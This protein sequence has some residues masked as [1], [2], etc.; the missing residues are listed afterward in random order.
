MTQDQ[1]RG[2]APLLAGL[3]MFGPFAIDTMFPAFPEIAREFGANEWLMQQTLSAYLIAYALMSLFHGPVSDTY[4]RRGVIVGSVVVFLAASVGCAL[5]WSIESLLFFRVV[6]GISAGA[7]QIVGRAIIRDL[8][9]GPAAQRLMSNIS[10]M[11]TIAPAVAPIVGGW[12]LGLGHW[13][14][15]FWFLVAWSVVLL[16]ACLWRLP[17]T[18]PRERRVPL[19]VRELV[20]SYGGM[21][22]DTHFWPLAIAGTV[23]FSAMFLYISCAP[24]FVMEQLK[25]S[26]QQFAWLFVPAVSGMFLGALASSRLAGKYDARKTVGLGYIVMLCASALNVVL[27]AWVLPHPMVPWSVLPIGLHAIGISMSFP[28]IA[29]L[30]I[31]RFP[32]HRGGASSMQSFVALVFN[33]V[34]AGGIVIYLS[35][36]AT[37]LALGSATL[38]VVGFVAWRV[39]RRVAKRDAL[40]AREGGAVV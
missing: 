30:V 33:A 2:L 6:Q 24:A 29:L 11:F 36:S 39:Y 27:S 13:R 21:V 18:H 5:A 3:A 12:M 38:T 9:E 31:D 7:G 26:E 22:R 34:L 14:W 20:K 35:D 32:T 16:V 8:Y 17:E 1:R 25:L 40:L 37:K 15:I 10:M 23:N 19:S 28:T 4:G